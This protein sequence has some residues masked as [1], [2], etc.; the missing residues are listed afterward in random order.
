V[1]E[2]TGGAAIKPPIVVK[3]SD[4]VSSLCPFACPFAAFAKG[5]TPRS[6]ASARAATWNGSRAGPSGIAIANA[7]PFG[8]ETYAMV[9]SI[10]RGVSSSL[11]SFAFRLRSR[12]RSRSGTLDAGGLAAQMR[13]FERRLR[14]SRK[15]GAIPESAASV[16]FLGGAR[17][18]VIRHLPEPKRVRHASHRLDA[19]AGVENARV[20]SPRA[21]VGT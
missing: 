18:L 3:C 14:S 1:T 21:G 19:H 10:A 15:R 8:T 16:G 12:F 7:C 17:V 13:V 20:S 11:A 2:E 4:A 6:A 9:G 5:A